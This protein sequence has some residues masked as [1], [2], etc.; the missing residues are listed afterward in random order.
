MPARP[1]LH[2]LEGQAL[3][4]SVWLVRAARAEAFS[5]LW[6]CHLLR[7]ERRTNFT[8]HFALQGR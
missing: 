3:M 6:R 4:P 2:E 7:L 1:I 8:R 5:S